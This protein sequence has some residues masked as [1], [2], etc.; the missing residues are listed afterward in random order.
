MSY[1]AIDLSSLPAPDVVEALDYETILQELIDEFLRLYPDY[2]TADLESDMV[3]GL[4]EVAALR[5]LNL[6]QRINDSAKQGLLAYAGGSNL[7]HIAALYGVVRGVIDQGDAEAIPPIDPTYEGDDALRQR[8]QLAPEALTTAGSE[9]SYIFNALSAGETATKVT[10]ESPEAGVTTVTYTYDPNS[11][12]G[13]IKDASAVNDGAGRVLVSVLG[14]EGDGAVIGDVIADVASH[15]NNDYIAPLTDQIIVQSAQI[16]TYTVKAKLILYD[17]PDSEVVLEE[18]RTR[19]YEFVESR[20]KLGERI[21]A[22]GLH[23]ALQVGGV[24]TVNL[25]GWNDIVCTSAQAPYNEADLDL[26]WERAG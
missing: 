25:I 15:L 14:R 17:G 11:S 20:H 9:G 6:R 26:T 16:V 22:S 21:T 4:F 8:V 13:K 24:Q 3:K 1:S 18:A 12:A 2:T 7:D 5:E 10:I 19:F 23:A